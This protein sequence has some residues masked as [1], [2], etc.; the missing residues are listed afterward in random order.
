M[1]HSLNIKRWDGAKRAC[2][3]WDS[4]K[5]VRFFFLFLFLFL[6]SIA[7]YAALWTEVD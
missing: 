6:F 2:V 3:R 5:R 7:A 1:P 4:L